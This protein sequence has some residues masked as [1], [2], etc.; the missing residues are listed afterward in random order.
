MPGVVYS[1]MPSSKRK[2]GI[3][4]EDNYPGAH[5]AI[6]KENA[7]TYLVELETRPGMKLTTI[8]LN[9]SADGSGEAFV[10]R[11]TLGEMLLDKMPPPKALGTLIWR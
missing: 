2:S 4:A 11:I 9:L 8:R 3:M 10:E 5:V 7:L 6:R 1:G